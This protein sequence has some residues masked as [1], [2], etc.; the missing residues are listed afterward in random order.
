[1]SGLASGLIL[2]HYDFSNFAGKARLLLGYKGLAYQS[3]EI[4]G[5]P[6]RPLLTPLIW[7]HNKAK[8]LHQRLL[9]HPLMPLR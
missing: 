2:H 8:L 9:Q 7:P 5:L 6:P 3:V 4:A 1:M